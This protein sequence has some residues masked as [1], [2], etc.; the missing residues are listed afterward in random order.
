[1]ATNTPLMSFPIYLC[2]WH[3]FHITRVH[4]FQEEENTWNQY[5]DS[6][7]LKGQNER[8]LRIQAHKDAMPKD[9]F[10]EDHFKPVKLS[11]IWE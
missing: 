9:E 8:D 11:A 3:R 6:L 7:D 5:E 1:M 10:L 2:S 4:S